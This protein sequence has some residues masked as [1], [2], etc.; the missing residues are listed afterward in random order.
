MKRKI[1]KPSIRSNISPFYVMN[2]LQNAK[3]IENTGKKVYHLELGEP[4]MKTPNLIKNEVQRLIKKEIPGYTP[5]NGI[6]PLRKKFL[7][8]INL[9]IILISLRIEF[10]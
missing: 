7:N 6:Y 4:Q 8:I 5:S 9:G 10:S 1:Y 3:E 2:L